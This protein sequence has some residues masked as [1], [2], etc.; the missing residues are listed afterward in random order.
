MKG[1]QR[2]LNSC[3]KQKCVPRILFASHFSV[4]R[5]GNRDTKEN[6]Q[7]YDIKISFNYAKLAV[8]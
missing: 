8:A 3:A 1:T 5:V 2:L 6:V 4:V 7:D